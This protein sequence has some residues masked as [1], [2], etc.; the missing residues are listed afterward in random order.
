MAKRV[1]PNLDG[2]DNGERPVLG[3]RE[4][5]YMEEIGGPPL[6]DGF[7]PED[8]DDDAPASGLDGLF[9]AYG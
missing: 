4:R 5:A 2:I 9:D 7:L 3:V 8:S 6:G 1:F